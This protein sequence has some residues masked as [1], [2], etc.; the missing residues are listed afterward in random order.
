MVKLTGDM[1]VKAVANLREDLLKLTASGKTKFV[2]DMGELRYIDSAGMGLM[3]T[4]HKKVG[5]LGGEVRV[6]N[7]SGAI[8]ELFE[9]TRLDRVFTIE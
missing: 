5:P 6:R 4:L 7:M 1:Y 9:Q 2:F 3:V 8:K